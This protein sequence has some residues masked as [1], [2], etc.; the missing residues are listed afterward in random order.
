MV[1]LDLPK[2]VAVFVLIVAIGTGALI[3]AGMMQTG[4]VLMMVMP[5][6]IVFGLLMLGLGVAHGEYRAAHRTR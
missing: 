6:M 3:G 2:T 4:T 1:E 5:S